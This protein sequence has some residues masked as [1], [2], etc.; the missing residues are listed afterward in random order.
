MYKICHFC[1]KYLT[2][3][4]QYAKKQVEGVKM[5][6]KE[7]KYGHIVADKVYFIKC[8]NELEINNKYIGY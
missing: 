4:V 5:N 8:L 2:F 7:I 3:V 1:T 6:T